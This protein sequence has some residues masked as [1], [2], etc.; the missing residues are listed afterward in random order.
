[1]KLKF[2]FALLSLSLA[3]SNIVVGQSNAV[4]N[5]VFRG[6]VTDNRTHEV[7]QGVSIRIKGTTNQTQ[8]NEKGEFELQTGQ[9]LPFVL[10]ISSTGYKSIEKL[11]ETSPIAILLETE[12]KVLNDVVV[13]GYGTQSKRDLTGAVSSIKAKDFNSGAI[14]SV[15]ALISGKAAGVQITQGSSEPGGAVSIRIRGANSINAS[16]EPLYVIDGLPIDNT[17]VTPTSSIVSEP[18][19]RNPLNALNPADILSVEILKD[20]SATAI[21]GSRGANG[22]ILITTK[23]GSKGALAVEYNVQGAIQN[24]ART[25]PMLSTSQYISLL[26]DLRAAVGSAPEFSDSAINAIGKGVDWQKEI[27]RQG[28]SQN[29]QL[30]FSGGQDKFTYYA[31]LNYLSQSGVILSSGIKRYGGR[32]NLNY[33]SDKF[34]FG[35]NLNTTKIEDDYVPNG[36]SINESGGIINSAIFQDPTLP[37][38]NSDGSYAQSSLVNLENPLGLAN[39]VYDNANSNRTFGNVFAEYF[40]LPELSVKVNAGSDRQDS[41]R[42]TYVSKNTKRGAST[43]GNGYAKSA[44]TENNLLE[45]TARYSKTFNAHKVELLGG[46]TFQNFNYRSIGA[47]ASNFTTDAFETNNLGAGSNS[48]YTIETYRDN[49]KLQSFLGRVNYSF[50]GKYLLTAN[51]RADGSSRFGA[52]NK[53][54]YFPSIALGWQIKD[55]AFLESVDVISNLKLRASYGKTGNQ[56][57]GNYRSLVLLG[58][59]GQAIF[60]NSAFA[61]I[62]SKQF[63]N[64]DLKW[65]TTH[66]LDIGL[67]FGF[68]NNRLTGSIDYYSKQT[69]DLLLE[70]PIP[71]TTGFSTTLANVGEVK[72]HGWDIQLNSVNTTGKLK[73]T[74][75]ANVSFVKNSVAGIGD[76][77][78]ILQGSA[79]FFTNFSIIKVGEPLNAY[80]G[81]DVLGVL[82]EGETYAPQPLSKPGEYKFRDANNDGSITTADRTILG[83]P[84][85]AVLYG[86]SNVFNYGSFGLSFFFQGA[87]GGDILNLNISESENPISFR[88]NRLER[89][90]TDRW[91]PDNPTNE[92]SSA[93]TPSHPYVDAS[94]TINSRAVEDA[95]YLRLKNIT[96]SYDIPLGNKKIIKGA[97]VYVVGQ[98][99]VTFSNYLGFDPE[100]SSFGTSNVRADYNA[101]PL[102][103]IYTIGLNVK[104]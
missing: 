46:Y 87:Q 32:V 6:K 7:L 37:V 102:S 93:L 31:S 69:Q 4:I 70:L 33:T 26:N 24:V 84:F 68:W 1:M 20:A 44:N 40:I 67:D 41:R 78:A 58:T 54:G 2:Y 64:A 75:S 82:Q 52:N 49:S 56:E 92:N 63:A 83:T 80:Y 85:P 66:Q 79:G 51:L 98:N 76:L 97:Q 71:I 43:N 36:T 100:I 18:T 104:F 77:T 45:L 25:V 90:Y 17:P 38:Y 10:E 50:A 28:Y 35:I 95:S 60:G 99:L 29:H 39:A 3:L 55:E 103:K 12:S 23:H 72:N 88:R 61:G 30:G 47:G 8:T 91:T 62:S 27:F 22:V 96:L 9:K 11:A 21:Y 42:D 81:Y 74:T 13:V 34:R 94:G 53:Y 73:W 101:Y 14:V 16:N 19:A 57:I 48:T 65:E 15:D 5:S 86:I 89:S 59:V